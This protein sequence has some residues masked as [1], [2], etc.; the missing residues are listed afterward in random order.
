MHS[1]Q[2]KQEKGSEV[3]SGSVTSNVLQTRVAHRLQEGS[4][5][6]LLAEMVRTEVHGMEAQVVARNSFQMR[7][8]DAR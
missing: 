5:K 3:V 2:R 4:A 1:E 6:A 7:I 8:T